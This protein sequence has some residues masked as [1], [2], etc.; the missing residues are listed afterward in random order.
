MRF[1]TK[2]SREKEVYSLTFS[3]FLKGDWLKEIKE[4][5]K[6]KN[7]G[8]DISYNG[9]K[10]VL[11]IQTFNATKLSEKQGKENGRTNKH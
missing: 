8:I 4:K 2:I 3:E 7:E 6:D 5:I 1:V 9:S 11:E 10:S